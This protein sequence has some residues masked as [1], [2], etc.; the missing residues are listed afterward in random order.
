VFSGTY[1]AQRRRLRRVLTWTP[2]FAG[3]TPFYEFVNVDD[4]VK[5]YVMPRC[6]T[7]TGNNFKKQHVMETAGI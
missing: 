1:D 5:S 2:A 4:L 3:V 7:V 6:G